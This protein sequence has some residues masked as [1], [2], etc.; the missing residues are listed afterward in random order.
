MNW[1]WFIGGTWIV[2]GLALATIIGRSIRLA[3]LKGEGRY[4]EEPPNT[5]APPAPEAHAV[6]R[7]GAAVRRQKPS[8]VASAPSPFVAGCVSSAERAPA[9]HEHR[10]S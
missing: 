2:V 7:S 9:D 6:R 1:V 4:R 10:V 5:V 3:T 8:P